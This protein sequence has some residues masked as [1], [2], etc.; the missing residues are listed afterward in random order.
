MV[1]VHGR[2]KAK[3]RIAKLKGAEMVAEIDKALFK[4]GNLIQTTAQ[5]SITD[6]AVSG[7]GHVPSKPGQ[8]PKADTHTLDRQIETAQVAPLT[9]EVSSNAPYSAM[10]EKGTSRMAARPFMGPAARKERAN[11]VRLVTEAAKRA[12]NVTVTGG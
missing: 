3:A 12:V 2:D 9:V 4:G 10:L 5:H 8:P 11:V 6:G 7:A 1:Q